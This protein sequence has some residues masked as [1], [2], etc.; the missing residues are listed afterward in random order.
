MERPRPVRCAM[1]G[2]PVEVDAM[3]GN[4]SLVADRRAPENVVMLTP[5][6]CWTCRGG[7]ILT[8]PR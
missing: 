7:V 5:P 6:L 1:C 3:A 4:L 2:A 8:C